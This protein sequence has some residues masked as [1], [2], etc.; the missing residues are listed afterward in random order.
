MSA[1]HRVSNGEAEAK[2][3]RLAVAGRFETH[4]RLE[5]PLPVRRRNPG[6]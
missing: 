2:S 4:K 1:Y 6:P 3:P 5:R